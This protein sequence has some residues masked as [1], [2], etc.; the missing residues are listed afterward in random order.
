MPGRKIIH[1][2]VS[3]IIAATK[4]DEF[5]YVDDDIRLRLETKLIQRIITEFTIFPE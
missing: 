2:P 3:V 4:G 5:L 1:I